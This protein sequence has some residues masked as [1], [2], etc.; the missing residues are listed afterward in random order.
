MFSVS[1]A[2][3]VSK[4]DT[5][6]DEYTARSAWNQ[7]TSGEPKGAAPLLPKL[8][9]EFCYKLMPILAKMI[10]DEFWRLLLI[11]LSR[12]ISHRV[13]FLELRNHQPNRGLDLGYAFRGFPHRPCFTRSSQTNSTRSAKT[14]QHLCWLYVVRS[15]TFWP[16]ENRQMDCCDALPL[17]PEIWP[18]RQTSIR[19][20]GRLS[21][22]PVRA[23]VTFPIPLDQWPQH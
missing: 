3:W 14:V 17:A 11:R 13:G 8:V 9:R 20:S 10:G 18:H 2:V 22:P 7:S 16:N 4:P 21:T 23:Q 12:F 15:T 5:S 19:A 6:N 1:F